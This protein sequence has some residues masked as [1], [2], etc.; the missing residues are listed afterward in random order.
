MAKRKKMQDQNP[1]RRVEIR[2]QDHLLA[3][4]TPAEAQL[5]MDNGGSGESGPM[6]IPAFFDVGEGAGGYDSGGERDDKAAD[7]AGGR[8]DPDAGI[9]GGGSTSGNAN[10]GAVGGG[11]RSYRDLGMSPGESQ[12]IF[13][14][15]EFGG[16]TK[17]QAYNTLGTG[18][19]SD[20]AQQVQSDIVSQLT[21]AGNQGANQFTSVPYVN[22]QINNLINEQLQERMQ[23][24]QSG[25]GIP[26]LLGKGLGAVGQFTLG[27]IGKGI[28]AGGR[29]VFDSSG[30]IAGVFNESPFG[31]GE[32][33]TGMPVEGVE[34]TGY[35]AGGG[36]SGFGDIEDVK[37]ANPV[38]GQCDEGYI[39]DEDLQ[40]CRLDTGGSAAAGAVGTTF[41]PGA[42]ARMGLLDVAPTGL[43]Q[44]SEQYGI[45]SQDFDAANLAFRRGTA[46]QAGIFQD[47]YDLTGYTLLG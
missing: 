7:T 21:R 32:V 18:G 4:I 36:E 5:L 2:G 33:Y 15:P 24:A 39:F 12:A 14:T 28:A 37:P 17:T 38:T 31:F 35:D 1:P 25:Y 47:P 23:Q 34:G 44:F 29:P 46:T 45:P 11:G 41:A 26:S 22:A 42:Y 10:A 30:N 27:R 20:R 40:A 43:P 6:G 3:Y 8:G 16:M 13:G 9:G 19:G